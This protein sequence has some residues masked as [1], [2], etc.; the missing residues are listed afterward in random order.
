MKVM[1]L[2]YQQDYKVFSFQG[3]FAHYQTHIKWNVDAIN[4]NYCTWKLMIINGMILDLHN[5]IAPLIII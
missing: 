4:L 5:W 2:Q 3:I 1:L